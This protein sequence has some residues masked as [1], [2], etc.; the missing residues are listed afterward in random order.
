MTELRDARFQKAL[1]S[2][3]DALERPGEQIA[4]SIRAAAR[5]A[6]AQ[7]TA[8][9]PAQEAWWRQLWTALGSPRSPWSAALATVVLGVLITAMWVHEPVP[10]ARPPVAP[11][12]APA[13]VV[14]PAAEPMA[15]PTPD[16][17]SVAATTPALP[18]AVEPAARAAK[19]APPA[20][21]NAESQAP[22][23]ND[24]PAQQAASRAPEPA[25]APAPATAPVDVARKE[26]MADSAGRT[27][28]NE[29]PQGAV[30]ARP[31]APAAALSQAPASRFAAPESGLGPWTAVDVLVDGRSVTLD[32][33]Q[34]QA[35]VRQVQSLEG[36]LQPETSSPP[37]TPSSAS[38]LQLTM[39]VQ[40]RVIASLTLR[41]N[42]M[43]WQR[44]R[45]LT[46]AGTLEETQVQQLLQLAREALAGT[47]NPRSS[48]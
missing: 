42:T 32:A 14:A 48:P 38:D 6:V 28:A 30:A 47:T 41:G 21:P 11:A 3:P 16:S 22:T 27:A 33:Q 24:A 26:A 2:A 31:S 1:E 4:E 46:L 7:P 15:A 8:A 10:D 39:R 20:K 36:R 43:R 5:S 37:A 19:A 44:E 23:S 25:A 45:R 13:P 9:V 29:S 17:A 34:A 40:D 35:L 18:A 12:P